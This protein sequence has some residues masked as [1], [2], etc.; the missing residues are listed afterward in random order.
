MAFEC[1]ECGTTMEV[2]GD[3]PANVRVCRACKLLQWEE[4]GKTEIR[5]PHPV[6]VTSEEPSAKN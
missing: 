2:I 4:N 5:Y 1:P 6:S 3:S